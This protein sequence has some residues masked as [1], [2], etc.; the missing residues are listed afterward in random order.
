V[1]YLHLKPAKA[2]ALGS[3]NQLHMSNLQESQGS[4]GDAAP[5][6]QAMIVFCDTQEFWP[7]CEAMARE[8]SKKQAAKKA[9]LLLEIQAFAND[10]FADEDADTQPVDYELADVNADTQPA[11]ELYPN[12]PVRGR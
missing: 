11:P 6:P 12:V 5:S 9:R 10:N 7:A 4:Q 3:R 8:M 2:C 1:E